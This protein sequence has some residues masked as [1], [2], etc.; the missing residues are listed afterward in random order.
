ML[1]SSGH[2]AHMDRG[3]LASTG[4]GACAGP[5]PLSASHQGMARGFVQGDSWHGYGVG[6]SYHV[7]G[8]ERDDSTV[9]GQLAGNGML[10]F[11]AI[12][13]E[14]CRGSGPIRAPDSGDDTA[15]RGGPPP[16]AAG[17]IKV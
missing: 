7:M 3:A 10:R 13:A 6:N 14:P 17:P 11:L 15:F 2:V 1:Y 12:T 4:R 5:T 16:H 9:H 8:S